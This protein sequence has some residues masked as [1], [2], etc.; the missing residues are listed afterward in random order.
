MPSVHAEINLLETRAGGRERGIDASGGYRPHVRVDGGELLGV[1]VVGGDRWIEPGESAVV[2]LE[3]LYD[4]DYSLLQPGTTFSIVE[5][6]RR[7]GTG[8]VL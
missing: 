2:D 7:V 6:P 4:V 5:G 3:L 8:V 1:E